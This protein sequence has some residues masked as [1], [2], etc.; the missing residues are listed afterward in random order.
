MRNPSDV[1]TF[2]RPSRG[3]ATGMSTARAPS[4]HIPNTKPIATA[5]MPSRDS[6]P[7]PYADLTLG[8]TAARPLA[9]FL[10]TCNYFPLLSPPF[11]LGAPSPPSECGAPAPPRSSSSAISCGLEPSP[12]TRRSS[13]GPW[14]ST[15]TA[16]PSSESHPK[17]SPAPVLGAP[18]SGRP[19]P[20]RG[21]GSETAITSSDANMSWL[22]VAGRLKPGVVVATARA[23]LAVIAASFDRNQPG[24]KTSILV[25]RATYMNLPEGR[26]PVL[27]VGAVILAAVSLVLVIACANLANLLLARAMGRRKEIAVR[28]AVGASRWRLFRQLLTESLLLSCAGSALG[29][30]AAWG[31]LRTGIPLLMARLPEEIRSIALNPNPDIRIVLYSLALA[32]ATGIGFGLIPA[33]QSSTPDLNEALK[34]S[35]ATTGGRR[36]GK[37]R[38]TLLA[39]QVAVCLVLLVAAGLLL[40]GLQSAQNIDLGFETRD[41]ATASFDLG[42]QGYDDS[43]APRPSIANWPR[44][45]PPAA[46]FP[47][48]RWWIPCR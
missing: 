33:L 37:L 2:T 36:T 21:S 6:P 32:L 26:T 16:S 3:T 31:T 43:L 12:R 20:C 10:V 23:E 27:S 22:E 8:G 35:G 39:T 48:P 38:S 40:R 15:T 44:A 24:R 25:D 17:A 19:S 28:L 30:L 34:D 7:T 1:V 4:C 29:L 11:A 45:S 18:T 41:I 14:C 47:I 5:A 46:A 9:G 13:A 42:R